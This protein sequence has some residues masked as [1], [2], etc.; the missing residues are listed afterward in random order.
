MVDFPDVDEKTGK[1]IST[2]RT[3][4]E[5]VKRMKE[6]PKVYG[7]LFK[8]NVVSGVGAGQASTG[9]NDSQDYSNMSAEEYRKNRA[10]I[11]NRVGQQQ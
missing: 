2:L 9:A 10:A 8:S 4:A 1:E 7:N 6:L 11:R 3:P 5:A